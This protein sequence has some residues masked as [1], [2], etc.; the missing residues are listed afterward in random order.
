MKRNAAWI[1]ALVLAAGSLGLGGCSSDAKNADVPTDSGPAAAGVEKGNPWSEVASAEEAA[2]KAGL[3]A[4]V[5]GPMEAL[6]VGELGGWT[7]HATDKIAQADGKIEGMQIDRKEATVTLS[8]RKAKAPE[9]YDPAELAQ[10]LAGDYNDYAHTWT[11]TAG[12]IQVTCFGDE[13]GSVTLAVWTNGNSAYSAAIS[14]EVQDSDED[15]KSVS[16]TDV[17]VPLSGDDVRQI[18][19]AV[20]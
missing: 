7:Y 2:K 19:A 17:P 9:K 4:F 5:L 6:T 12:D 13:E 14:G 1:A 8:V 20:N 3:D 10:S 11:E 16:I 18:V 15:S